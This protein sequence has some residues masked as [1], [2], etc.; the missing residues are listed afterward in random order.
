MQVELTIRASI[1]HRKRQL[2]LDPE[3]IEFKDMDGTSH[4]N[5]RFEKE[6]IEGI[7]YGV[8][9]INGYAFRIGRLYC[10]D[11]KNESGKLIKLRF[12]SL[13]GIYK[14]HLD[15][16]YSKIV[17]TLF[18]YYYIQVFKN[19]IHLFHNKL[20]FNLLGIIFTPKGVLF[21]K[22]EPIIIWSDLGTKNY[23]S[24]FALFS[25]SNPNHYK[26]FQYLEDWNTIILQ[27]VSRQILKEMNYLDN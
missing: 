4:T 23:W 6:V 14:K 19:Y 2:I 16:K 15:N 10:I 11:I 21:K 3:F 25:K 8:R 17:N 27:S 13:Y 22:T 9:P 12:G 1:F 7:R 20:E 5:T 24:Y 26:A 18:D